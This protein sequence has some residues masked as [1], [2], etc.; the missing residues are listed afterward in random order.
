MIQPSRTATLPSSL[1]VAYLHVKGVAMKEGIRQGVIHSQPQVAVGVAPV[2]SQFD[3]E[4]VR[5]SG[6]KEGR[7]DT[8]N[9]HAILVPP[10]LLE[11]MKAVIHL[12][13]GAGGEDKKQECHAREEVTP[14]C[15]AMVYFFAAFSL[16]R[17]L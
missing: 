8:K 13:L 10:S 14:G 16:P 6:M 7:V 9:K 1:L 15:H 4:T 12:T 3:E 11:V 2:G 5:L 17:G